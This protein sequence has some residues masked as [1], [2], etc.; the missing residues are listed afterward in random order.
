M[1]Y[2]PPH[3]KVEKQP[4]TLP[5][6]PCVLVEDNTTIHTN[7]PYKPLA[8]LDELACAR[9]LAFTKPT[10]IQRFAI[11]VILKKHP[12]LVRAPTGMGKTLC[13]LLPIIEN[14]KYTQYG[15]Q[16]C[17][18]TPTRELCVQIKS[19][20]STVVRG[21]G[22]RVEAIY[23]GAQAHNVDLGRVDILVATPGRLLDY[24]RSDKLSLKRTEYFVLDEA[25]KLLDMGFEREVR[26]IREHVN[27]TANV[28]LFSATYNKNL[29][30]II[31][32]FLPPDRLFVEIQNETVENIKQRLIS[33]EA[34]G[35]REKV[36]AAKD[37]VLRELLTAIP[38]DVSWKKLTDT[39]KVLIFVERKTAASELEARIN[40]MGFLCASIHGDKPQPDR[41]A[42]LSR[43]KAG[44]LPIL[45][46]TSVAARGI[47]VKDIK[48]VVNYDFPQDIKEYIHR[49]GRTG[50]EGKDGEAVSF[51]D[52]RSLSAALGHELVN[53]LVESKNEVP[54]FLTKRSFAR[55]EHRR[56]P[57]R[58]S[59]RERGPRE[60]KG[61]FREEG[62]AKGVSGMSIE[63]ASD[64][65]EKADSDDD[66]PGEW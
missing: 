41:L 18:I 7:S 52:N 28:C 42:I 6:E 64:L 32:C 17:I 9:K 24:L 34:H 30:K 43:F 22:L 31:D 15:I 53:V 57:E 12:I 3:L 59:P 27:K 29:S 16:A 51:I 54:A 45:V 44:T 48:L 4:L 36:A 58:S 26:A 47:D 25:D 8:A 50:R 35:S 19:E 13:F 38:F 65:A 40:A 23:G 14:I 39:N 21:K 1:N 56:V 2:V 33:V 66:V 10:P 49:I 61:G 63:K 20:A 5:T 11:P 46:A 55:D 62:V 60:D 37:A